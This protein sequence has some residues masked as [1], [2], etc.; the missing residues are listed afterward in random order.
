M[1]QLTF[2]QQC[3]LQ[4][5]KTYVTQLVGHAIAAAA[6]ENRP[7]REDDFAEMI[8]ATVDILKLAMV[9]QNLAAENLKQ[10]MGL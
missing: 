10:S 6:R 8:D 5:Q 2:N 3:T 7:V 9:A 4:I 1:Q